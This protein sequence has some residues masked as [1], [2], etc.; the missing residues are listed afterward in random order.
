M[1]II[2]IAAA[3]GATCNGVPATIVGMPG[4]HVI[5]GTTGDDVLRGGGPVDASS[6]GTGLGGFMR[7]GPGAGNDVL[8]GGGDPGDTLSFDE[9]D[10]VDVDLAAGTATGDDALH[11]ERG[12]DE[13]DGGAGSDA[14]T[15]ESVS[16]CER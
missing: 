11:G 15:G 1:K 13:V 4:D 2:G 3:E 12:T 16:S 14:C 5:P 8:D 10:G 9:W 7:R 6:G